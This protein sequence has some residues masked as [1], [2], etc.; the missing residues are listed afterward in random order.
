MIEF[1]PRQQQ[2]IATAVTVLGLVTVL[3]AAGAIVWLLAAFFG[4]FANVFLPLAVAGI[5]AMVCNPY[6]DWLQSRLRLSRLLALIVLLLTIIVPLSALAWFFGKMLI[7]EVV[8]LAQALPGWWES[9][10]VQ[11]EARWPEVEEFM[12]GPTG[13]KLRAAV[14][15]NS[16]SIAH[17]ARSVIAS[18][19][20]AGAGLMS[21]LGGLAGWAVAPVYFA[22]FLLVPSFDKQ[23][24]E[25]L[26]PFLKKDRRDDVIF[27]ITEFVN[28]VVVFFRGQLV[29]AFLQG[30]LYATGFALVGLKFGFVLGLTLGFLN[31]VPY[32]GAMVGFVVTIPLAY[33]QPEGG[34]SLVLAVLAVIAV[35]QSIESYLLTPKIMGDATGLHPMVIIVAMFFWGT[36][37]GGIMGMIMA[38]PLTAF[39]V[40]FWR[41]AKE[42]YIEEW[43]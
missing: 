5:M 37:F 25:V 27:L 4:K 32:L 20:S 40:V 39:G 29:I 38:I 42:K 21:R 18:T 28:I 34:A 11:V 19:F 43:V 9:A 33:F 30:L 8:D 26:L 15:E 12:A 31:I 24:L 23:R 13:E 7:R 16:Q 3:A 22:F 2:I 10:R 41:L 36:A 35:V 6:H 17:A 1:S 14:S